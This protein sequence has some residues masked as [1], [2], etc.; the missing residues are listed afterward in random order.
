MPSC[1]V[2][3]RRGLVAKLDFGGCCALA[4]TGVELVVKPL[5][6]KQRFLPASKR[7]LQGL[8]RTSARRRLKR[9]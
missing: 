9:Q 8:A 4:G 3:A 2:T 1:I 7:T 5:L 6:F